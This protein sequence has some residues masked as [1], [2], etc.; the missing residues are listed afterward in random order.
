MAELDL[1][2]DPR[3][4]ILREVQNRLIAEF[5]RVAKRPA[6]HHDPL[7]VLV[8]GVIGART[9]TP[10]SNAA[11]DRLLAR[12]KSWEAVAN[13]PVEDLTEELR[14]QTYPT[15]SAQRLKACLTSLIEMRGA[16]DLRHLSNL[17]TDEAMAWLEMLPGVG[18]KISAGVM[19]VGTF[20]RR[21]TVID[22]HHK[23]V[24]QRL[25]LV[26]ARSDT[27]RVFEALEPIVPDEW[28][29]ETMDEHHL[30]VKKLGQTYCRPTEPKCARCPMLDLCPTGQER[31]S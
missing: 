28:S 25:R 4:D 10:V 20:N 7:W 18:R 9:K 24:M 2:G 19:N 14:Y 16:A 11:T 5:G 1:G 23:R 13:V 6:E 22:G 17:P 21:A 31:M 15:Q 26:P 30:L 3:S 8:Q 12:Y 29:G 27:N